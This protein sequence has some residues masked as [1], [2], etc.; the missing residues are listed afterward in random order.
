M[1]TINEKPQLRAEK[2]GFFEKRLD[3]TTAFLK[4]IITTR[5]DTPITTSQNRNI[6]FNNQQNTTIEELRGVNQSLQKELDQAKIDVNTLLI[7]VNSKESASETFIV[8]KRIATFSAIIAT[9]IL[10]YGFYEIGKNSSEPSPRSGTVTK[11]DGRTFVFDNKGNPRLVDVKEGGNKAN[12][13][14]DETKKTEEE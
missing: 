9:L 2:Q 5:K 11:I 1:T 7:L 14:V 4:K 12:H 8:N 3:Y 6:E 13:T 10:G